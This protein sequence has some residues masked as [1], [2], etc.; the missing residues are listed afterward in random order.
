MTYLQ[1]INYIFSKLP[2]F[3][4]TGNEAIK[5][6]L[7]NI[8]A[9][10]EI[11]N[12][13]Q[14]KC[15]FIHIA[16]TNGKGSVS[17]LIASVLQTAGYKTGLYT[18]PHLKDLR[19]RIKINGKEI[20]EQELIDFIEMMQPHIEKIKPSFF[21]IAVAMAFE[22]FAKHHCDIAVIE[23]G[24]G[25]RLDSTNII[26]PELSVITNISYD[27]TKIL[28]DTLAE[29]AA[30]KAGII[31]PK[32][33]VVIGETHAETEKIFE[34]FAQTNHS[35][36]HFADKEFQLQNYYYE[37]EELVV[38]ISETHK[39]DHTKYVL[40]LT[41]GY[42]TK[43]I[44]TAIAACRILQKNGWNIDEKHIKNGLHHAK[45][46]TGL[47]GRWETI[48]QHPRIVL[49]VAHN[50]DGMRQ[51]LNQLEIAT[52]RHLHIVLGMSKDK[53]ISV[54]LSMLPQTATYY[55]SH[56]HV[57]RAMNVADLSAAASEYDLHGKLFENVNEAIRAA[58]LHASKDDLILV[59]GSVFLVGEVGLINILR[60]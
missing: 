13:P 23:T 48:Q 18:S 14:K 24:L 17:H 44:L 7:T 60:C 1:T 15:K 20:G 4:R 32:I 41:A 36:I 16:G 22:H 38:E 30:E 6:G 55:F 27:H 39:T 40:D 3:S 56:A 12:Q 57:P 28:G 49:D 2:M 43:N 19:E 46:N 8:Y 21:E 42:Q 53:D 9:L 25:G 54:V 45:K 59:C 37:K 29:I 47:H 52:Y 34:M 11:L 51:I 31:K 33:P 10:C 50:P 58:V 35:E 26:T 5:I